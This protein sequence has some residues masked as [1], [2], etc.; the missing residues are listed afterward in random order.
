VFRSEYNLPEDGF[1]SD[2]NRLADLDTLKMI[3]KD[4]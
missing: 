1:Q 4:D 3:W 2:T